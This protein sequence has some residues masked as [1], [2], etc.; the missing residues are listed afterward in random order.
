[1][2]ARPTDDSSS[3]IARAIPW[4]GGLDGI[5]EAAG[6]VDVVTFD[7][8]P[9]DP[10]VPQ[11]LI[12]AGVVVRPGVRA[13]E[14][15]A[16]KLAQRRALRDAG[17]PVPPFAEV[18]APED[19]DGF[20][21]EHGWPLVLKAASG[22]Y[23]GRGVVFADGP[24]AAQAVLAGAS[25]RWLAE[26]RLPL[27]RELAVMVA[28]RPSGER[29]TYPVVESVQRDGMCR[30]VLVPAPVAPELAAEAAA[31]AGRIAE[32]VELAGV[33]AV[34]LFVVDDRIVINELACRT[35]NSGHHS[36]EMC[37]T[38]QFEN[39]LRAV[40]DW[41]LGATDPRAPAAVMVNVVA[42]DDDHDPARFVDC[43][44]A[45]PGAH[46]HVYGKRPRRERKVGHVTALGPDLDDAGR[47]ARAAAAALTG[48][49]P[50]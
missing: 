26:P 17:L 11:A 27:E 20:A 18:A 46:V 33:M 4:D 16:D 21:A 9:A 8:D 10:S 41:P 24:D 23:D 36:I 6:D 30:E 2:L 34:E 50:G 43:A 48:E 47:R 12:D 38:S 19:V 28:R 49:V 35:H 15:A 45:V 1:M 40:L 5:L 39:H 32:L 44:L 37:T 25:G 29:V 7:H 22:G 14:L 42:V 13:L 31:I 3:E